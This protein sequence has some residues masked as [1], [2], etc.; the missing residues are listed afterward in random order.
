MSKPLY[1][2]TDGAAKGNSKD[3][4][5]G[6]GVF[7]PEFVFKDYG[8]LI[9]TNNIAELYAIL[10]LLEILKT[11]KF[12]GLIEK[13]RL[14]VINTDSKYSIG[15][16]DEGNKVNANKELVKHIKDLRL[17]LL[18]KYG[19]KTTFNYVPGHSKK[20]TMTAKCNNVVDMLASESAKKHG[21][22]Y[23]AID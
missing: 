12:I 1:T 2:Y 3:S 15:V 22:S 11:F 10:R 20:D 6:W 18:T 16:L 5:A 14:V 17:N 4:D 19:I 21:L 23:E 9:G 7:I 8:F 13:D